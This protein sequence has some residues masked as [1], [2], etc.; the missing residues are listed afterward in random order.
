LNR[1]EK[2]FAC[3]DGVIPSVVLING[4]FGIGKTSVA[5]ELRRRLSGSV[6]YDPEWAGL[7][8]QYLRRGL[9]LQRRPGDFQEYAL[10]QRSV[11]LGVRMMRLVAAGPVLVPMAFSDLAR[12]ES[13]LAGIR[14][15]EPN[16]R[17]F[18]LV[19]PL[20]T[21]RARLR[22][23]GTPLD[24]P[25]SEFAVRRSHECVSAHADPRFGESV[26]TE[27]RS[28]DD[29]ANTILSAMAGSR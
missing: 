29:V 19:A 17:A 4:S 6:I 22:G 13:I 2:P 3:G 15:F 26:D 5:R 23:R 21:V 9:L 14:G 16:A 28:I 12:F 7:A 25:E 8:M 11:P 27:N 10:W 24:G 18:C 20:D 1:P